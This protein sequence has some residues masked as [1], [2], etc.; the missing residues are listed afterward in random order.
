MQHV[1][2]N[3]DLSYPAATA[4]ITYAA[5]PCWPKREGCSYKHYMKCLTAL[6]CLPGTSTG[7]S[8]SFYP[9]RYGPQLILRR[10]FT[11]GVG[12][13]CAASADINVAIEW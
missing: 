12:T 5:R 8:A 9:T 13:F 3:S 7:F 6:N 2:A 1:I 10:L 4:D 11:F